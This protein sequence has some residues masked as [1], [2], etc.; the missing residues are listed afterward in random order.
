[1]MGISGISAGIVDHRNGKEPCDIVHRV[2]L[3]DCIDADVLFSC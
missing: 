3:Y 1:M 2:L